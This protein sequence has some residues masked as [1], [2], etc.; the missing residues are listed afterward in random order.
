MCFVRYMLMMMALVC[1][2]SCTIYLILGP[3]RDPSSAIIGH[4]GFVIFCCVFGIE[5][6]L[7]RDCG[8]ENTC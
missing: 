1:T 7:W 3:Y 2:R 5:G 8:A 4:D 6:L